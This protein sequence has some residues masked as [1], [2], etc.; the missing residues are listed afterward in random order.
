VEGEGGVVGKQGRKKLIAARGKF[1]RR[2]PDEAKLRPKMQRDPKTQLED[3][4]GRE[5]SKICVE[6]GSIIKAWGGGVSNKKAA[7]GE[8]LASQQKAQEKRGRGPKRKDISLKRML[9]RTRKKMSVRKVRQDKKRN[10]LKMSPKIKRTPGAE[11]GLSW[12]T[13]E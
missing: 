3:K 9:Q 2:G 4:R 8:K 1:E 10:C 7:E 13:R 12:W 6:R 5:L 11:R